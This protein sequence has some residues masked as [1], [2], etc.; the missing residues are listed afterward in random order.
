MERRIF[1][2]LALILL[3]GTGFFLR[4]IDFADLLHFELDQAR[5]ARVVDDGLDGDMFDLPLLG[6]RAGGTFL[7]LGPGFYYLQ[8]LSATLFGA[9]PAGM[10]WFVP[11]LSTAAIVVFFFFV[12]RAFSL[13]LSLGL[14]AMF[15][16][17]T[18]FVLYGRF[19]WNPN[20]LP[21]FLIA[22]FLALLKAVDPEEKRQRGWFITAA[23][24][25]AFATQLHFLVFVSAPIIVGLFLLWKRPR[26]MWSAWVGALCAVLVLYMPMLLNEIET[27]GRNTAEFFGAVTGKSGK[28]DHPLVNK[29][30]K[31]VLEQASGYVVVLSGYERGELP[32]FKT[33]P[34]L[35][36]I[37]DGGCRE[38]LWAGLLSLTFAA[39]GG[40]IL[41]FR[42]FR[43]PPSRERDFFV[44]S[45]LWLGVVFLILTP[46]AFDYSARFFLILA[47]L[48]FVLLGLVLTEAERL[49]HFR[50][51]WVLV[52]LP[53]LALSVTNLFFTLDRLDQLR[54]GRTEAVRIEG[55]DRILKEKARVTLAQQNDIVDYMERRSREA[56]A[57]VYMFS[58]PEHRRALKYLMERRGID[59]AVLGFD[60]VYREGV[61]FLILRSLSNLENGTR[62]YRITY[63]EI[64][65]RAF[66]SLTLFE[67]RPKEAFIS[68]IR[69]DFSL[70]PKAAEDPGRAPR[71]T[72]REWWQER[73]ASDTEA[74]EDGLDT[75]AP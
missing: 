66:G 1:L 13:S 24:L 15:A 68:G 53:L 28:G 9:D 74:A 69:Q 26:L 65:R 37:C 50:F 52:L 22:G 2:T 56:N 75:T 29:L 54:Q 19:A 72:W 14:S 21:F 32:T 6:P 41:L 62:K 67:F 30:A 49:L 70:L 73:Q 34:S 55:A 27:G 7:R 57:P 10:A 39:V 47:P 11:I 48:P 16:V 60:G 35:D 25:L 23:A 17:S 31:N 59:N 46:I 12:R 58:E 61:Y 51:A 42:T 63:D 5:D 45:S 4:S 44:L 3:I 20:P 8:Y 33:T 43:S 38:G 64:D 36:I 18:Y 71:Y 40:L